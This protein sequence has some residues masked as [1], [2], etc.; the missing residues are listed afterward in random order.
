MPVNHIGY[1]GQNPFSPAMTQS[2]SPG[3][4][5][6]LPSGQGVVGTFGS[7]ASQ[8]TGFTLSGQY[9]VNIGPYLTVQYYD[10]VLQIWR[11]LAN[12][13]A[14]MFVSS[15]GT[16]YRVA[17]TT[18]TPVG[19]IIT[20]AGSGLT[21]GFN[22]VTVTPSAGSSTWNTIV[23]GGINTTVTIT[24]AGSGYTKPPILQFNPP[25]SQ[26]STPYVLP[27]A[28]CT[29]S[30]GAIASVTVIN[31]GAGLVAA[32]TITVI[33][34]PGD[35]T[36][37]GGVLTVNSTL[38]GSGTLL[39]MAPATQGTGLTAVPTFTFSPASTIAATA[40]MNF[41]VTGI[42]VTAGGAGYGNAQPFAVLTAGA[43]VAGSAA[44]TNPLFDKKSIFPRNVSIQG[45]STAGGA[46]T[47]T[48]LVIADAGYGFQAVPNLFILAGGSGLASGQGQADATV[49]GQN[50]SFVLFSL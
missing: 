14:P 3:E 47:A 9:L 37:S 19:A 31:Q 13:G 41:T 10:A 50:D 12:N 25:S 8:F 24:T 38:A 22:T 33:N 17:N 27:T 46:I 30:A 48:G 5:F 23:G 4:V 1:S 28:I 36:G 43:Q 6:L 26:G 7:T 21:N 2:L 45:T 35:T 29:I 49:G 44:N 15:D 39:W 42:S 40:I 34:Q 18:G 32:P 16:N 20:N 11:D